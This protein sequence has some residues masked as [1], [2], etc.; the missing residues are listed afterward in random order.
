[1]FACASP[2]P[3]A[4]AF[5]LRAPNFRV[6]IGPVVYLLK[7]ETR[8]EWPML[9]DRRQ[10]MRRRTLKGGRI[11]F[12]DKRSVLDCT[13]HNLSENGAQLRL[14]SVVGVPDTFELHVDGI[15]RFAWVVWKATDK[16][17]VTWIS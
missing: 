2:R 5:T 4:S 9:V 8:Y 17:G 7:T 12:D 16:L 11:V 10:S 13:V 1:M 3:R 15:V 14:P 6:G